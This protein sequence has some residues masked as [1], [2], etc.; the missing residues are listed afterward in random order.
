M[1]GGPYRVLYRAFRPTRWSELVGQEHVARSLRNAVAQG[2][3]AHAYLFSGPRGTGKTTI[4]RI[5][6]RALNCLDADGGE[7]CGTCPPCVRIGDGVSTDVLELDAASNRGVDEMRSLREQTRYAPVEERVKVYIVD[8]VHMLTAEAANTLLKTLEEPP[9]RLVFALCTTDPER[10]PPTVLSRCQRFALRRLT[11]DEIEGRLLSVAEAEGMRLA[12][13]AARDLA[14]RAEGGLRDGLALLEQVRAYGGDDV[15]EAG[16]LAALGGLGA[17]AMRQLAAALATGEAAPLIAWLDERWGEGADP[18]ALAGALRDLWHDWLLASVGA[19]P[20]PTGR[21]GPTDVAAAP[22]GFG[23]DRLRRG[24]DQWVRAAHDAR[25]SDDPRLDLEIA[26]L[27]SLEDADAGPVAERVR[28]LED[29]LARL[30]AVLPAAG[31][32][33]PPAPPAAPP[34]AARPEGRP[35]PAPGR[36]PAGPVAAGAATE[37]PWR[38]ALDHLAAEHA[39]VAALLAAGRVTE[40][41]AE[42][43][44]VEV[45]SGIHIGALK[46]P[47]VRQAAEA[48]LAAAYGGPRHLKVVLRAGPGSG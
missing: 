27:A 25:L 26:L 30:E 35:A 28:D 14:R 24:L 18:R 19:A 17:D 47:G 48:A 40:T 38:K 13:R 1:A 39:P 31:D 23:R 11:L 5:L 8:E 45:P 12:P 34:A 41:S 37:D 44:V 9:P 42:R 2:R 15:D 6:A 20:G 7:P 43:V 4:A 29:R 10:L 22:Q 46:G 16:V 3:A 32:P 21:D 36:R 33:V